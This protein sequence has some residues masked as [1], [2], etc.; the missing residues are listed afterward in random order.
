MSI[1]WLT[2]HTPFPAPSQALQEPNGLLAAGGDLTCQ[3]LLIAYQAGIFPWYSTDEPILWWSPDP[4]AVLPPKQIHISRSMLKFMRKTDYQITLNHD[5]K[6]VIEACAATREENETWI[7]PEIIAAY[8]QLHHLG[9]AHSIEVWQNRQLIGGLYGVAQ[10]QL[11]CG[12]SMFS[13]CPNASKLAL[14]VFGDYFMH[15]GG[16]LIDCQVMNPHTASLGAININRH[17]YLSI[18]KQLQNASLSPD[19]WQKK[20]L[21][22]QINGIS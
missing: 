20:S 3:R 1:I 17:D 4:R 19:F 8:L 5:F 16:Q 21:S 6:G 2:E 10:G 22:Y 7:T 9:F 18:L 13:L 11:F 14:I 12:E 15:H